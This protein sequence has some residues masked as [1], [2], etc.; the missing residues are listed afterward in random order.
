[1]SGRVVG[2]GELRRD[3]AQPGGYGGE[4]H[5]VGFTY[6]IRGTIA[7]D[8]AGRFFKLEFRAPPMPDHLKLEGLDDE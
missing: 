3:P 6:D 1:M 4:A 2:T 8:E 7:A 5:I